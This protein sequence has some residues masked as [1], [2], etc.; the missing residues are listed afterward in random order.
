MINFEI[1]I[2]IACR[3]IFL[4][5][6]ISGVVK[7]YHGRFWNENRLVPNGFQSMISLVETILIRRREQIENPVVVVCRYFYSK[8]VIQKLILVTFIAIL[9][10]IYDEN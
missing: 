3:E 1:L 7:L 9:K 8:F 4:K 6:L 10:N 2:N 5:A